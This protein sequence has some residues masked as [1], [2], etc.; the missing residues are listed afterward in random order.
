[1]QIEIVRAAISDTDG[2]LAITED[3]KS[4]LRECGVDQWQ[5]GYPD[6]DRIMEDIGGYAYVLRCEGE[7]AAYF[8]LTDREKSYDRIYGGSWQSKSY[9]ALHRLAVKKEFRGLKIPDMVYSFALCFAR[10]RG[11]EGLR[12]DTH[13]DN[14]VM[15]RTLIRNGFSY[16]GT[17]YLERGG[18]RMAYEKLT[19]VKNADD[20]NSHGQQ[21]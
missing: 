15:Q 11:I 5:D 7:P 6:K 4:F 9:M 13:K 12:I 18:S 1:M 16:R 17:I 21:S 2:I 14:L 8:F 19:G 3:A 10:E 20:S